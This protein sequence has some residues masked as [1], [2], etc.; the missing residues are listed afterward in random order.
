MVIYLDALL[1]Q[2]FIVNIFLLTITLQTIKKRVSIIRLS[3]GALVGSLYVIPM[4][5]PKYAYL[6]TTP[7]KLIVALVMVFIA[8]NQK[9][10][11]FLLKSTLIL[12][13][14]T[15][16]LGG[17]AFYSALSESPNLT[18][19]TTIYSF[20]SK[21]TYISIMIIYIVIQ[22]MVNYT[23][24]RKKLHSFIYD[25]EIYTK[26]VK[27]SLKAFLD[28]GNELREPATNLPVI[29]VEMEYFHKI[30]LEGYSIYHIPYS[31][32]S[33]QQGKLI[34]I[35]PDNVKITINDIT[36]EESAIIAFC[37][38]KLSKYNDYNGL[39]PRGILE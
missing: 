22:R 15:M 12:I 27:T 10:I 28:T 23:R 5:S 18:P 38:K 32:V 6:A 4:L 29:I 39:L 30:N 11:M 7:F 19:N 33:G 25:I 2:N 17:L 31:V 14:Y 21:N 3:I 9:N 36:R 16:L 26:E 35:K 1:F 8:V 34:G 37:D 20:S 24:D 13:F